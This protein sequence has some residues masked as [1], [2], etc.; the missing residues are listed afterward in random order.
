[1][2]TEKVKTEKEVLDEVAKL[3]EENGC[4][5]TVEFQKSIALGSEVLIYQ[6]T[7]VKK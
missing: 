3:L 1:M 5:L 2:K 7:V 6:I 4:K